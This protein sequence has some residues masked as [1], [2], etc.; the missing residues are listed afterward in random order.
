MAR[1]KQKARNVAW[2]ILVTVIVALFIVVFVMLFRLFSP[3]LRGAGGTTISVNNVVGTTEEAAISTLRDQ[4]LAPKVLHRV[5]SDE[6]EAGQVFKQNP[7]A[8]QKV[9]RGRTV[10]LWVSLGRASF[11]VPDLTDEHI[12]NVQKKLV[13]AGLTTGVITKVFY[14]GKPA[15]RVLNQNPP[16]GQEFQA[17]VPVDVWVADST[18]RTPV[19][20]PDLVGVQLSAAEEKLASANL[21]LAKVTYVANDSATRDSVLKQNIAANAQTPLG[22]RVEL[23][24]AIPAAELTAATK[25]ITVRIPVPSGPALQKVRIKVY[26]SLSSKGTVAFEEDEAPGKVVEQ[27]LSLEGKATV[28]IFIDSMDKPYREDLL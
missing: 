27:K 1:T 14:E 24:V 3:L 19:A 23:E 2:A 10:L 4:G 28:Q 9:K 17:T 5:L 26:D 21:H 20:M 11:T 12:D 18:N 25:T 16:P 13:A 6:A 8:G 22:S 7:S 15:G